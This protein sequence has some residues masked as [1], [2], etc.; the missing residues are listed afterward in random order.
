MRNHL[1]AVAGLL[2]LLGA[3][4]QATAPAAIMLQGWESNPAMR[5]LRQENEREFTRICSTIRG[6][7]A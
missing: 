5:R 1:L 7:E 6:D 4:S 2:G 3:C